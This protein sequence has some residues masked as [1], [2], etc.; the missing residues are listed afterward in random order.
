[1][2]R[3]EFADH[4]NKYKLHP[5]VSSI[6]NQAVRGATRSNLSYRNVYSDN[7]GLRCAAGAI[8]HEDADL[9]K[10]VATNDEI[11]RF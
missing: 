11:N 9:S 7:C 5:E 4:L 8:L 6:L 1:M 3:T 10:H 2:K